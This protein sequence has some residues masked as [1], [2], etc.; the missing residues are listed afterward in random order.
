MTAQA[1]RR[2]T[3]RA[4]EPTNDS[5]GNPDPGKDPLAADKPENS[6]ARARV[7]AYARLHSLLA[8]AQDNTHN[9]LQKNRTRLL[10]IATDIGRQR[11]AFAAVVALAV[12]PPVF[13]KSEQNRRQ[14]RA[15]GDSAANTPTA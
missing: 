9:S 5:S 3:S 15:E 13:L 1:L 8:E 11:G 2:P 14:D 7:E 10:D 12:L 4:A 6:P